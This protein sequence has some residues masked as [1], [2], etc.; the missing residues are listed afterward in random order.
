M[1]DHNLAADQSIGYSLA[2]LGCLKDQPGTIFISH[3]ELAQLAGSGRHCLIIPVSP[4][5]PEGGAEKNVGEAP[6]VAAATSGAPRNHQ[7]RAL[8]AVAIGASIGVS[9]GVAVAGGLTLIIE[10]TG[11]DI[12]AIVQQALVY[13]T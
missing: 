13:V 6:Q 3:E 4:S 7:G 10:K 12:A 1:S 2:D 5:L 9:I 11:L 8:K